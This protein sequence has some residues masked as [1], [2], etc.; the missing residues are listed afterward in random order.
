VHFCGMDLCSHVCCDTCGTSQ[1]YFHRCARFYSIKT[2][3]IC[4]K[5]AP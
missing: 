5:H 4:R 3:I 2:I 1:Y